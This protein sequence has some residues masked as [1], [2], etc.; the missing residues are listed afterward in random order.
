[1]IKNYKQ[2]NESLRD[3]LV[4][5]SDD[6]VMDNLKHLSPDELLRKSC[7]I[8]FLKGVEVA[9]KKGADIHYYDD[10]PLRTASN[11]GHNEIVNHLLDNVQYQ[12]MIAF[13]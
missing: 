7:K 8:G 13:L 10:V 1:M 11:E 3:K 5:P 12:I 2:F 4:G 9:L 6:E